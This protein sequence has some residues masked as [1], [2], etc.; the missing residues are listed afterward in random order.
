MPPSRGDFVFR[1]FDPCL[2]GEAEC[3][4][5]D[6]DPGGVFLDSDALV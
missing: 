1:E 2:F 5:D 4:V 3:Y 6:L